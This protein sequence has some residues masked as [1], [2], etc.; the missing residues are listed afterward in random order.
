ME[1]EEIFALEN[2]RFI[3]INYFK[4]RKKLQD[5]PDLSFINPNS[6]NSNNTSNEICFDDVDL[7]EIQQILKDALELNEKPAPEVNYKL[8]KNVLEFQFLASPDKEFQ[9]L[10]RIIRD[11]QN[12]KKHKYFVML[13]KDNK[14]TSQFLLLSLADEFGKME[15]QKILYLDAEN[16]VTLNRDELDSSQILK[17]IPIFDVLHQKETA[18][19]FT[20]HYSG[21]DAELW[22]VQ[23][24]TQI[25]KWIPI[26]DVVFDYIFIRIPMKKKN[27]IDEIFPQTPYLTIKIKGDLF[28]EPIDA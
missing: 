1:L 6:N 4:P 26:F 11:I 15:N 19:F 18:N 3:D 25:R 28:P 22:Q 14:N 10:R 12:E 16:F 2:D 8:R 20:F 23:G 17:K 9:Q 13:E 7:N 21:A 24:L 5:Y 27:I